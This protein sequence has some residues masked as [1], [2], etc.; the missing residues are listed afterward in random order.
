MIYKNSKK[1]KLMLYLFLKKCYNY[2]IKTTIILKNKKENNAMITVNNEIHENIFSPDY[3]SKQI[4][5]GKSFKDDVG[6]GM[7]DTIYYFISHGKKYEVN[8]YTNNERT[9][10]TRPINCTINI[11][12]V[13]DFRVPIDYRTFL[14]KLDEND[15]GAL[16]TQ[17]DVVKMNTIVEKA[18]NSYGRN[19]FYIFGEPYRVGMHFFGGIV[20]IYDYEECEYSEFITKLEEVVENQDEIKK[21]T[22][23]IDNNIIE[24]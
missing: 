2:I 15:N 10:M 18:E 17:L 19:G 23:M 21:H 8:E 3:Y 1:I 9:A 24:K 13:E 6:D 12:S 7:Q 4:F 5:I 22:S 14:V 16:T 11:V 20:D